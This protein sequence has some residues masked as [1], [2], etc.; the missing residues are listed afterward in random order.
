MSA[1]SNI[2]IVYCVY[3]LKVEKSPN[4]NVKNGEK[5]GLTSKCI[6]I[7]GILVLKIENTP[8]GNVV[9]FLHLA[10]KLRYKCFMSHAIFK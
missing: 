4:D 1:I 10:P 3:I 9:R 5:I 8:N 7:Y 6:A 2:G